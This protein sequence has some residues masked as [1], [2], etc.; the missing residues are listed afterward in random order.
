M[1]L[2]KIPTV[3]HNESNYN[4]HFIIKEL[5]EE[6]K[7]QFICLRENTEKYITFIVPMGKKVTRIDKNKKRITKNIS[8]ILQFI[9]SARFMASSLSNHVIILLK[10]IYRIKCKFGHNNKKSEICG[11][12]YKHCDC[13]LEH[14]SFKDDLIEHT[15]LCCYKDYQH[16]F[17]GKSKKRCFDTYKFSNNDNNKFILFGVYFIGVY[18]YG[19]MDG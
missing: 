6:F 14:K 13:F 8:S 3:F 15:C 2:K 12:K 16:N 4:Y 5:P 9:D 1:Y 10:G 19:Y 7:K 17:G 11:I 18:P